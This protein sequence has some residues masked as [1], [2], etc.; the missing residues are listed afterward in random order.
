MMRYLQSSG[1]IISIILFT[2][3]PGQDAEQKVDC[4][5]L[6]PEISGQYSGDCKRGLAHGSGKAVGEDTYEGRFKKGLPHGKGTYTFSSGEIFT[7]RWK[8]G[9]RHGRGKLQISIGGRD[10]VI[11]GVW[12]ND[13]FFRAK[14]NDDKSSYKIVHSRGIDRIRIIPMGRENEISIKFTRS[15]ATIGI[16]GLILDGSSGTPIEW[17]YYIG[18]QNVVFPFQATLR[19]QVPSLLGTVFL[20]CEVEFEIYKPDGWEVNLQH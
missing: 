9:L 8:N 6:K 1:L 2:S 14:V 3:L 7:G 13:E 16:D 11:V 10:S 4:K 18:F 5:V 15:G 12:K 17:P 19:Y 20:D